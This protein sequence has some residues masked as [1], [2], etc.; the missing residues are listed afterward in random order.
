MKMNRGGFTFATVTTLVVLN[1]TS[2]R[3]IP[4]CILETVGIWN[5][6]FEG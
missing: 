2:P 3:A 4:F 1:F 6:I 5:L